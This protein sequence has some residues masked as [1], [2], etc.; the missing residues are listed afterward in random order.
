MVSPVEKEIRKRIVLNGKITFAE[1]MAVLLYH[2][3]TGYYTS[4]LDHDYRR[5]YFT[6]PAAHPAFGALVAVF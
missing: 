6:S 4:G 1:F 2:P 3:Q 5:D